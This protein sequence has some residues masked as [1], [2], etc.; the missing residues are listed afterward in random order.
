MRVLLLVPEDEEGFRRSIEDGYVVFH[1][2]FQ[3]EQ[4]HTQI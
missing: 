1:R 2:R 4:S 3:I